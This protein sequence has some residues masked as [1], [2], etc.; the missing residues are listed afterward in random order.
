MY[1]MRKCN[2]NCQY[3]NGGALRD[4][5]TKEKFVLDKDRLYK[6]DNSPKIAGRYTCHFS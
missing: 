5:D 4:G 1:G 3:C 2:M 6:V